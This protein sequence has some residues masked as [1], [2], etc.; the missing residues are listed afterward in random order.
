MSRPCSERLLPR[1]HGCSL[2]LQVEIGVAADVD[3]YPVQGA[4]AERPWRLARV[5]RGDRL[6]A[7]AP[8][9][10]P[11]AGDGELAGLEADSCVAYGVVAVVQRQRALG[12]T[13]RVFLL[14]REGGGQNQAN[15]GR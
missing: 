3:R 12:D 1:H 10:Q 9:T 15:A 2:A 8:D 13:G 5:S 4:A 14:L 6:S 11:F 7:V